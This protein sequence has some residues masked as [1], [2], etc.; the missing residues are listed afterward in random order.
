MSSLSSFPS[1]SSLPSSSSSFRAVEQCIGRV[2]RRISIRDIGRGREREIQEKRERET[3][4]RLS[5]G[6]K[7]DG[8]ANGKV[9]KGGVEPTQG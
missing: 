2:G 8:I 6:M 4:V 1:S 3:V 7:T 5:V 9:R